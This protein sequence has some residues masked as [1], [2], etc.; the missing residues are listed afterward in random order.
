[1]LRALD[2]RAADPVTPL[3][4]LLLD[5]DHAY[6]AD[7]Y[8]V[9]NKGGDGGGSGGGG[10]SGSGDGSGSGG[11]SGSSGSAGSGEGAEAGDD[12]AEAGEVGEAGE[13][14]EAGSSGPSSAWP[15]AFGGLD[16]VGPDLSQDQEADAISKGWQ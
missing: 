8:L 6:F 13:A 3:F 1:M 14:G 4:N 5:G 12:G 2:A 15:A 11:S 9:H 10:G 7:A 16:R